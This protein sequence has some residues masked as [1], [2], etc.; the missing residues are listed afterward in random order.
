MERLQAELDGMTQAGCDSSDP[1]VTKEGSPDTACSSPRSDDDDV[2]VLEESPTVSCQSTTTQ[3]S[4]QELHVVKPA[5]IPQPVQRP[6][7]AGAITRQ[8]KNQMRNAEMWLRG[9]A[10]VVDSERQEVNRKREAE[11]W[12]RGDV[13]IVGGPDRPPARPGT[14]GSTTRSNRS[15]MRD[16]ELQRINAL[17]GKV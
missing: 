11:M 12:L 9:D 15:A 5:T 7:T 8:E 17:L 10:T 14:A 3:V 2:L 6:S 16:A 1:H 13:T 4:D